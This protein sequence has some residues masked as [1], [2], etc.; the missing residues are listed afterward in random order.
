MR[1]LLSIKDRV[2]VYKKEMCALAGIRSKK[3][4][5]ISVVTGE[6]SEIQSLL[7]VYMGVKFYPQA[8]IFDCCHLKNK[9]IWKSF[10]DFS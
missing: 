9:N 4:D 6:A 7:I 10:N 1:V 8:H 2:L 5:E 3:S